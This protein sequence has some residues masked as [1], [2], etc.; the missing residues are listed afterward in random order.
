L[1]GRHPDL[2]NV[3]LV[4]EL[5]LR[6]KKEVGKL[7]TVFGS[8]ERLKLA[9]KKE[10]RDQDVIGKLAVKDGTVASG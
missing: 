5:S 1:I 6:R 4:R 10:E 9:E 2:L 8:N 3:I 7:D